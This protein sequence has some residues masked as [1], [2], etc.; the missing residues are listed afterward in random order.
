MLPEFYD[1]IHAAENVPQPTRFA[2]EGSS[3]EYGNHGRVNY[4]DF[5]V[6]AQS[7]TKLPL[8]NEQVPG[9]RPYL[10]WRGLTGTCELASTDAGGLRDLQDPIKAL[11]CAAKLVGRGCGVGQRFDL[12]ERF[13]PVCGI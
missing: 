3:F 2:P 13:R 7:T 6:T 11:P 8:T 10:L 4:G 9:H 1:K 5:G 12:R